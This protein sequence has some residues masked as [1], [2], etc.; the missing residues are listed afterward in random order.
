MSKRYLS[1]RDV[2]LPTLQYME[3]WEVI[4]LCWGG[5]IPHSSV[6]LYVSL[7]M[8]LWAYRISVIYAGVTVESI[9]NNNDKYYCCYY[10]YCCCCYRGLLALAW[11]AEH[12]KSEGPSRERSPVHIKKKEK[13]NFFFF[14]NNVNEKLWEN[15]ETLILGEYCDSL[16]KNSNNHNEV[17][18]SKFW[19][20]VL[21]TEGGFHRTVRYALSIIQCL[22]MG[23]FTRSSGGLETTAVGWSLETHTNEWHHSH[24]AVKNERWLPRLKTPCVNRP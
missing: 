24:T 1:S 23:S 18:F 14:K 17:N 13:K 4:K 6:G 12:Q 20:K 2:A 8:N 3:K 11:T 7:H 15:N 5:T 19:F 10:Y 9:F 22:F 16:W 21:F